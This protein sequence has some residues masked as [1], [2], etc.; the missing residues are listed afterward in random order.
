MAAWLTAA[1]CDAVPTLDMP[2][3]NRTTDEQINDTGARVIRQ[4][5]PAISKRSTTGRGASGPA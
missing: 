5:P 2:D 1:G 3:G 4:I